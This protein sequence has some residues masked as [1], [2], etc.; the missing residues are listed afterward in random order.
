[1]NF[2]EAVVLGIIE[3]LTEFLPISSTGHLIL[4]TEVLDINPNSFVTSF[5]I[6]IQLGAILS[7]V[8][9]Y[10]RY[11]RNNLKIIPK[12]IASFVPTAIVGYVAYPVIK[13]NFLNN[14]TLVLWSLLIGGMVLIF[15]ER[16]QSRRPENPKGLEQVSFPEAV[17][18]GCFQAV[19]VIPGVS[20]AAATIVGGL[21]VGLRR[22]V[23][24]EYSF[25]LAIPTM[26]AATVLDLTESAYSFSGNEFFLLAVGFAA[27]FVVAMLAVKSFLKFVENHDFTPFGIYRIVLALLFW[28]LVM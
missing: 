15:F 1:M 8:F 27:S 9:L 14:S 19:S 18:I 25:L 6:T 22:S 28:F 16:W 20:R 5:E 17:I 12:L 2:F 7:V 13:H 10:W 4:A 11:L 24:V 23:I 21:L 26:L 3:G